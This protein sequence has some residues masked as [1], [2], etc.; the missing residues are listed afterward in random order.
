[1]STLISPNLLAERRNKL[2]KRDIKVEN[3]P[4][5]L[6]SFVLSDFLK[7]KNPGK[8]LLAVNQSFN[9]LLK[10]AEFLPFIPRPH[11]LKWLEGVNGINN[12]ESGTVKEIL[13]A[14]IKR[15]VIIRKV[16]STIWPKISFYL[17]GGISKEVCNL[18]NVPFIVSNPSY[19]VA[20]PKDIANYAP[21]A[22]VLD[23]V[24]SRVGLEFPEI[25]LDQFKSL[26]YV[27][28][29]TRLRFYPKHLSHQFEKIYE[30]VVDDLLGPK[31]PKSRKDLLIKTMK[32]YSPP[33]IYRGDSRFANEFVNRETLALVDEVVAILAL[34]RDLFAC[35]HIAWSNLRFK[36]EKEMEDLVFRD[37][38]V[39]KEAYEKIVK[40]REFLEDCGEFQR[41]RKR[42]VL[43]VPDSIDE[44]EDW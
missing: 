34:T 11:H 44:W 15:R 2:I 37:G 4:S 43:E 19:S 7:L 14:E 38:M 20:I 29:S 26:K 30:L 39:W 3:L 13:R 9:V 5:N 42:K 32:T 12:A 18:L 22:P 23:S 33:V 40:T 16:F 31:D 24:K 27:A 25:S 8:K 21:T 6:Q 1:M 10:A 28:L 35:S 41:G 17:I 36:Y